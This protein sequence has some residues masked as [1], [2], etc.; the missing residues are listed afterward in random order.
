MATPTRR[1]RPRNPDVIARDEEIYRLLA[2]G[3][4]SRSSL[5]DATGHE[6]DTVYLSLQ[7]LQRASRIRQ[8][9]DNGS[10]VWAVNDGTP[11]P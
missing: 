6:R 2:G 10:I 11:C 8:C 4:R 9:L 3:P 7:R 5:A 1:G